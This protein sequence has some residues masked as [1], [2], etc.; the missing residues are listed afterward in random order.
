MIAVFV[1]RTKLQMAA[2]KQPDVIFESGQDDVLVAGI[3]GKDNLVRIDV[4]FRCNR[5]ALGLCQTN[6]QSAH[7]DHADDSQ[8]TY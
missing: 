1:A 4:V 5:D 8:R 6:S 2:K 7:E 3:A